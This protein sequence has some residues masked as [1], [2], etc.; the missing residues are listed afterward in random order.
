MVNVS[1]WI[2]YIKE[3]AHKIE[4]ETTYLQQASVVIDNFV[5]LL[6]I[7]LSNSSHCHEKKHGQ[8]SLDKYTLL[9]RIEDDWKEIFLFY[10]MKDK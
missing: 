1:R 10:R 3:F 9:E 6:K 7:L 2:R 5:I 4:T 8:N